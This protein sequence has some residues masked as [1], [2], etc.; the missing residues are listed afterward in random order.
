[1]RRSILLQVSVYCPHFQRPVAA[2]R[3]EATSRLCHCEGNLTCRVSHDGGPVEEA[4]FPAACPVYPQLT[5]VR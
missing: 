5:A 4:P 3:N 1:M 2:S